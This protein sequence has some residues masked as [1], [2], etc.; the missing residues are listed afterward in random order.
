MRQKAAYEAEL[1]QLSKTNSD[2]SE[3]IK[4]MQQKFTD[5]RDALFRENEIKL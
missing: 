3:E 1:E 4:K 5:E 2:L